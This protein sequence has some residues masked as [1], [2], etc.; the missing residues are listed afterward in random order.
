MAL[1]GMASPAGKVFM[2]RLILPCFSALCNRSLAH[3]LP[4]HLHN[5][6]AK[7][8]MPLIAKSCFEAIL[9]R[10]KQMPAGW[11]ITGRRFGKAWKFCQNMVIFFC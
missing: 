1:F 2:V 5:H 10:K 7:K 11:G 6:L 8:T 4:Q 3:L 9:L